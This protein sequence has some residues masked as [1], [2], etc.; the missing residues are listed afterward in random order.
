[1]DCKICGENL[2]KNHLRKH[3]IS[4]K[5]YYDLYF[6]QPNEEFCIN[7]GKP[8]RYINF[9]LG[10][11]KRCTPCANK[12][13]GRLLKIKNEEKL[14]DCTCL[15]CNETFKNKIK[16]DYCGSRKCRKFKVNDPI[17]DYTNIIYNKQNQCPYCGNDF[18]NLSGLKSHLDIHFNHNLVT[19]I[20]QYIGV[21]IW[22][23][24]IPKC[25]YCGDEF[26]EQ[27]NKKF[28]G[29]YTT[30]CKNCEKDRIW[31]KYY[32]Y[33]SK[34]KKASNTRRITNQTQE[35]QATLKRVGAINS[36]KMKLFN[37]TERGK[38]NI[39][40]NAKKHSKTMRQ[41]IANGEFTPCITNT[42]TH[43][44]AKIILEDNSQKKFR[45]SWEAVFWNSNKHLEFETLR[46]PWIDLANK[47]H[48]YIVDFYD[49]SENIIYE[50]KPK[51]TWKVQNFKMQQ[52]IRYCLLNK[53]KFIWINEDNILTFI[54]K[55]DFTGENLEQLQKVYNGIKK[56][57]DTIN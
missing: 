7:C 51:S 32:D 18:K 49:K 8:S 43:W 31:I 13:I 57:K 3:K 1:M 37:Q 29:T 6:K 25:K 50:V 52:I 21:Y 24:P 42:W 30:C 22:K 16:K 2:N 9:R 55:D 35:G 19:E 39:R 10:Y 27:Y 33:E 44:E 11:V 17:G 54:N 23:I 53:I 12:E 56:T 14:I 4:N 28:Y 15:N 5:E 40:N 34:C 46:I 36:I 26:Y 41:K 45:S 20:L 38:Q 47:K 48:S